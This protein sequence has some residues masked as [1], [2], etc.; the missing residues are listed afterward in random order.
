[1]TNPFDLELRI[2]LERSVLRVICA[3]T[4]DAGGLAISDAKALL[5]KYAWRDPDNRVVFESLCG[6]SSD[7]APSQLREQLPA[8]ATRLGFPDVDWENY[9]KPTVV[10][11]DVRLGISKLL[12]ME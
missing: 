12:A 5:E 6:L 8:Q 11:G 3:S 10:A 9:L 1:V 4:S 7:L 2:A